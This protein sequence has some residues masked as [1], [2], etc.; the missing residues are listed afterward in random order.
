MGQ[1]ER[2][3]CPSCGAHLILALPPG[4]VGTRT[5]RCL[6][7]DGPDPLRTDKVMGWLKSELQ[8]P[9]VPSREPNQ[10]SLSYF[11]SGTIPNLARD[12]VGPDKSRR[13]VPVRSK[14]IKPTSASVMADVYLG[15]AVTGL[16]TL[17]GMGLIIVFM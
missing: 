3:T 7:C 14:Q 11:S 13:E 5:F 8:P 12:V 1:A 16:Y 10:C 9:G 17:V 15:V 6:E 4:V 2:P